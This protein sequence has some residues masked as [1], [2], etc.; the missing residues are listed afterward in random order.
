MDDQL[1]NAS[2]IYKNPEGILLFEGALSVFGVLTIP[3][4]LC[5]L[6]GSLTKPFER[7]IVHFVRFCK[8]IGKLL[9]LL[10]GAVGGR[11]IGGE[12]NM[13]DLKETYRRNFRN[14]R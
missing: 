7:C 10:I 6:N 9:L 12:I 8:A 14:T 5:F 11:G 13:K 2:S 4:F 3:S 1:S